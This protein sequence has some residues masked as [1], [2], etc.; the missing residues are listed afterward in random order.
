MPDLR[1]R[2]CELTEQA[3]Q[4][5]FPGAWKLT[6]LSPR[7]IQLEIDAFCARQRRETEAVDFQAW[8]TG[9]YVLCALHAP[10]RYP[11][12]PDGMVHRMHGM[13]DAQMK[14]VFAALAA[15]RRENGRS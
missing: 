2:A 12:R 14:G 7:E 8:L 6:A 15:E 5:G 10:R 13:T 11:R 4:A 9:R 1:S 3:A